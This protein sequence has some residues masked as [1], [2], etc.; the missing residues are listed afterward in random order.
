MLNFIFDQ[1]RFLVL[2]KLIL[3]LAQKLGFSLTQ[4]LIILI[5]QS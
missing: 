3:L 4:K 5:L 1:V 2:Q